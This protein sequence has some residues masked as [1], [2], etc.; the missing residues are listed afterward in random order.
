MAT[1]LEDWE[2]GGGSRLAG[3]GSISADVLDLLG[4]EAVVCDYAVS[5]TSS[6]FSPH[7]H[8]ILILT[9]SSPYHHL[10]LTLTSPHPHLNVSHT[11]VEE[12]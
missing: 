8:R 2:A 9:S 3:D 12:D 1:L 4:P 7:P 11:G 6:S 10:I 5:L